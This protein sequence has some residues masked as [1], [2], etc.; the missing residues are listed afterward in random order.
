MKHREKGFILPLMLGI[1]LI[2]SSLLFMLSMRFEVKSR[3]YERSQN[4]LRLTLLEKEGMNLIGDVLSGLSS[5]NDYNEI[6]EILILRHDAEMQ[7]E[8]GVFDDRLKIGYRIVYGI[9][10]REGRLV[11]DANFGLQFIN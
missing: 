2:T 3:S 11:Y 1:I 7:L 4:F 10:S 5:I 8:L 6:P 9:Y